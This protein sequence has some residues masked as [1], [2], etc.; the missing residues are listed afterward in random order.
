[1]K[2]QIFDKFESASN[3]TQMVKNFIKLIRGVK[4]NVGAIKQCLK[5]LLSIVLQSLTLIL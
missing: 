4:G 2:Q 1:M 3:T 5:R